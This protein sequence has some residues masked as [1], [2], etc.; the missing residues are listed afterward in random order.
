MTLGSRLCKRKLNCERKMEERR[1]DL[2]CHKWWTRE[3]LEIKEAK[4]REKEQKQESF[5]S[6][7]SAAKT[8]TEMDTKQR[9]MKF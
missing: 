6:F 5:G 8:Q 4:R 1:R 9:G 7:R 3:K 2:K